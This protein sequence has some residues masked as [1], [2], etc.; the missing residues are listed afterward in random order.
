MRFSL[1]PLAIHWTAFTTKGLE[2]LNLV[3]L[4]KDIKYPLKVQKQF[5]LDW[6]KF[7]PLQSAIFSVEIESCQSKLAQDIFMVSR[8]AFLLYYSSSAQ[9]MNYIL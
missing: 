2:E 5:K 9:E 8:I 4:Y 6:R 3:Y 7:W 1:F